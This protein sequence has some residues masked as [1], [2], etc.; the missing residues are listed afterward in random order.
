MG[1]TLNESLSQAVYTLGVNF[2][3]QGKYHKALIIFDGL[4]ALDPENHAAAIAYG[5]TL[6]RDGQTEK[7]LDHFLMINKK[8]DLD[9]RGLLG[10]AKACILLGKYEEAQKLVLPILGGELLA[11]KQAILSAKSIASAMAALAEIR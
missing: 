7:A 9:S 4:M 2:F 6:L 1:K 3:M 5:E 11:H 10:A 8:F